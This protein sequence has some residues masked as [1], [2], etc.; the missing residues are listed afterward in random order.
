[1]DDGLSLRPGLHWFLNIPL[2]VTHRGLA[3]L[4]NDS[5]GGGGDVSRCSFLLVAGPNLIMDVMV[6]DFLSR[7]EALSPP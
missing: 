2:P 7:P 5:R 1:M 6:L 3:E 4:S